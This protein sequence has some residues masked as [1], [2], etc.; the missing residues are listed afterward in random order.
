M[1]FLDCEMAPCT[2]SIVQFHVLDIYIEVVK[3]LHELVKTE[4]LIV[5]KRASTWKEN[6]S[7]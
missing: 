6:Q 2:V 4:Q 7:R 1:N 5:T 3:I